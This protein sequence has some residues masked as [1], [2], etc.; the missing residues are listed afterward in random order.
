MHA[1]NSSK[2]SRVH[3]ISRRCLSDPS[4]PPPPLPPTPTEKR[5]AD[6]PAN[7]KYLYN[8]YIML[9]QRRRRWADVV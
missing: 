2:Y 8:I 6:S 9:D 4:V 5:E 1:M 3:P 7:T